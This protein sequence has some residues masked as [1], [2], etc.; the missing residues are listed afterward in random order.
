MRQAGVM[1]II[2][3]GLILGISRR[4][5][6]NIY[7]L[8]GGKFDPT[9]GDITPLNTAVRETLEETG[10]KVENAI[11]IYQRA[12]LGDGPNQ[13]DFFSSC[14]YAADWTGQ[15]HNSEEGNVAWLTVEEITT[16]KAAFGQYNKKA[17]EVFRK[18]FPRVPLQESN[19]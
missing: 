2:K 14:Y 3:D 6:K 4:H 11:F 15:P 13:E 8:P 16:T 5:N 10:I 1:L 12:E 18:M 17:I 7:G 9:S 19:N